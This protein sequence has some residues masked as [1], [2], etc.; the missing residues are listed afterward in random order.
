[1]KRKDVVIILLVIV[2]VCLSG[3]IIYDKVKE[4][5]N[6]NTVVDNKKNN[7]QDNDKQENSKQNDLQG[8]DT[9][10]QGNGQ[11]T[12]DIKKESKEFFD[13]YLK[14][15]LPTTSANNFKRT[16]NKFSNE[17]ISDYIFFYFVTKA[18][19]GEIKDVEQNGVY[20]TYNLDNKKTDEVVEKYFGIKDYE[21][22]VSK[23]RD[24]IRKLEDGRYQAFWFA[25]GWTA[26]T[27]TNTLVKY[28]GNN[29]VVEYK[30]TNSEGVVKDDGKLTFNLVYNNGNYNVKSIIYDA[31]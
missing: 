7:L 20:Y 26:P 12:N 1:M 22:I 30:L 3:Y 14:I 10:N 25:T 5:K 9:Q 31:A 2:V 8:D 28:N 29:V 24:G 15:F 11:Q 27:A 19:N 23:G 13:E 6:D 4:N 16:I 18:N 17:D 21:I